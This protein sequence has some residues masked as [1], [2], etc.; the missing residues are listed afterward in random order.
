MEKCKCTLQGEYVTLDFIF[1]LT[2]ARGEKRYEGKDTH[3]LHAIA[4]TEKIKVCLC[5]F[6]AT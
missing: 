6:Q 4:T 3:Q 1:L 5:V 2:V